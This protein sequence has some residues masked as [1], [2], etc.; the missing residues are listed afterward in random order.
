M[1]KIGIFSIKK[2]AVFFLGPAGSHLGIRSTLRTYV[3]GKLKL[4]ALI[5]DLM[6]F[7]AHT[8]CV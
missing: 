4:E 5:S 3:P 2:E 8:N 7:Y 1:K 6:Y